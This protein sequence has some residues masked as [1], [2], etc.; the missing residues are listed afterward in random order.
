MAAAPGIGVEEFA[1][2]IIVADDDAHV[3]SDYLGKI[4]FRDDSEANGP[5]E[6]NAFIDVA[7]DITL[8]SSEVGDVFRRTSL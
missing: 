4:F 5:E 7:L 2:R 3:T 1:G 8:K 6:G